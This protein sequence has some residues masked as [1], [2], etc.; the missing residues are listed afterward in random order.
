MTVRGRQGCD[1]LYVSDE[2]DSNIDPKKKF[3]M[4]K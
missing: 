1:L 4:T 2:Y 3:F